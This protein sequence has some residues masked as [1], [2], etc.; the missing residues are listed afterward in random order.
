[1]SSTLQLVPGLSEPGTRSEKAFRSA[2]GYTMLSAIV[3]G[4]VLAVA[5]L[6]RAV[7][8][9][10][11]A[12]LLALSFLLATASGLALLGFYML[13]PNEAKLMTLFG[14]YVGTDRAEGLRWANPFL[15]RQRISLRAR[16]LNTQPLKVKSLL[17]PSGSA[18]RTRSAIS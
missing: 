17:S 10:E 2:S 14:E 12:P 1:M 15:R 11:P 16:N 9:P 4:G 3:L 8:Q 6:A 5:A 7:T 13:A 18:S